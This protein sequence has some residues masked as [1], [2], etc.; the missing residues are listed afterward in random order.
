MRSETEVSWNLLGCCWY[1]RFQ[2]GG[3]T[4][5]SPRQD[6]RKYGSKFYRKGTYPP[7]L[8]TKLG[9][10]RPRINVRFKDSL[11]VF[12]TG[13][14]GT[15]IVNES[16]NTFSPSPFY[17]FQSGTKERAST[18]H[19]TGMPSIHVFP[20]VKNTAI[21]TLA[22]HKRQRENAS[23]W[24]LFPKAGTHKSHPATNNREREMGAPAG[25]LHVGITGTKQ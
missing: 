3:V 22:S 20:S 1:L 13:L 15:A 7:P 10:V 23:C 6:S 5:S 19:R 25:M 16:I 18:F 9:G 14:S 21:R 17:P 12:S 4:S 8:Y 11:L 24:C 2:A